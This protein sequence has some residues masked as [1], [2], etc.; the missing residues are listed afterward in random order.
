MR[1]FALA[2]QCKY[3]PC[4]AA[5]RCRI[6]NAGSTGAGVACKTSPPSPFTGR[7]QNGTIR[8]AIDGREQT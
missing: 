6:A 3:A 2:L 1:I 8:S 7:C 5:E 4:T